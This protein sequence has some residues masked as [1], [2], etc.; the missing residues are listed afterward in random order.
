MKRPVAMSSVSAFAVYCLLTFLTISPGAQAVTIDWVTVSDPA[1]AADDTGYGSVAYTYQISTFETTNSQYAGFLNAI[2]ASDPNNVYDPSTTISTSITRTG[3]EGSFTYS[4]KSGLENRPVVGISWFS[5]LRFANW[6]HNGQPTGGQDASTTE[7]G[8]YTFSG[9]E[10]VGARNPG[11]TIVLTSEDEWYKAAYYDALSTSYFDYPAG[12]DSQTT[13]A[14]PGATPNTANCGS[15]V[16]DLT[17][18]GSYTGSASPNGTFDQGGNVWEWNESAVGE[19]SN[20]GIR[21]GALG[22]GSLLLAAAYRGEH[23]PGATADVGFRVALVPEPSTALLLAFGLVGLAVGRW[24][25]K[26]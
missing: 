5:A 24:D 8:S 14:A 19:S 9:H 15:A 21:G 7:D 2:A 25:R 22:T 16:G 10:I 26:R 23:G 1:N 18:V 6:L 3:S 4:V 20:R 11:T 13:C 17:D 12:T